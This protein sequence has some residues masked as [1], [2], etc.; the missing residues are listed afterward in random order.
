MWFTWA[1][2]LSA[3]RL[4][5]ALPC[6]AAIMASQWQIAAALFIIAVITDLSDGWLARRSGTESALGGLIDHGTDATFV[7]ITLGAFALGDA[8]PIL[9]P[10]LIAISF[11]QY[12]LDSNA[13]SGRHL[14]ASFLG[15]WNGIAYYALAGVLI[16]FAL[17]EI[18]L[19]PAPWIA[20]A[21]WVL[22][23]STLVSMLDR[24]HVLIRT[25]CLCD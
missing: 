14:R 25:I 12:V 4:A 3:V 11:M 7:T 2:G 20:A 10:V 1:N 18:K 19:I 16:G 24:A 5:S 23:V 21:G 6:A 17:L 22:V 8:I 9:L 15:R 13:L